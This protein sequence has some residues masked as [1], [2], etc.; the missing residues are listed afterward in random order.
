M[1]TL[2]DVANL[3]IHFLESY[4]TC[5]FFYHVL[6]PKYSF[7][8]TFP[9]SCFVLSIAVLITHI[10]YSNALARQ[11][12]I[13]LAFFLTCKCLYKDSLG[14]ILFI[15]CISHTLMIICDLVVTFSL[16]ALFPEYR[17][18][19]EGKF[20]LF[21]NLLW[22]TLYLPV[23][24]V[25][26]MVWKRR[27]NKLLP[28]SI[29]ITILFPLSQ[30]FLMHAVLYYGIMQF[31]QGTYHMGVI[32]CIILGSALCLF[33]DITLFQVILDNSK[34]ERLFAQLEL[35]N[36]QAQRELQYYNSINE[37]I[38]EIRKIRHD[39]NNQLQ[40]AYGAIL[41]DNDSGRETAAQLLGQLE[42]QIEQTAPVYYC[43]NLIVNVILAE[44]ARDA[45][46]QDISMDISA[47]IPE[48]I[49]IEKVDLCSIFSNLLDNAIHAAALSDGVRIITV[50]AWIRANYCMIEV[51][52]PFASDS[53]PDSTKAKDDP[54]HGLG[55]YILDS[56]A[57]KYQ[58]EFVTHAEDGLFTA[59]IKLRLES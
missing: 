1:I 8:K 47:E 26:I 49:S 25:F 18:W 16:Y 52:N 32:F 35:M 36:E 24:Y 40:T 13:F 5:F 58:G 55:L 30:F 20:L 42:L 31:L 2:I 41:K 27:K 14:S 37:K 44:K 9:V 22:I 29:Y 19:P 21:G 50:N 56:I 38:Q 59:N 23:I 39:F 57:E 45:K 3:L 53:S 48:Q 28:K 43:P 34:K 10:D 11:I 12:I 6:T 17:G 7:G 54:L 46:T 51:T 15:N 33:A 4:M